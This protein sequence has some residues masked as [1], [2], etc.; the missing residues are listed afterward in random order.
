MKKTTLLAL[1][2]AGFAVGSYGQGT[3]FI[4]NLANTGVFGG[5]GGTVAD[6]VYSALVTQNGLIFTTDP[7]E[8]E[9]STGGTAGSTLIGDDFS[10]ELLGGASASSL[11]A[12]A[13]FTG[14][15][16]VGD[17]QNYGQ[18]QGPSAGEDVPGTTAS[19]T[20]FLELLVWEGNSFSTYAAAQLAGDYTGSSGVFTSA[21]GGGTAQPPSLLSMP[22]VLV[23]AVP[24][25]GT[26]ALS[27][28]GGLSLFLFRRKK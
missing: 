19:S 25:P 3:I 10:W 22:D 26:M 17:N 9:G 27:A 11:S 1:A 18:F 5:N 7:T 23:Q 15:Q 6:P 14:G 28:L 24:E 21:S 16:I 13:S 12:V 8:Q 4:N 20:V 2:M